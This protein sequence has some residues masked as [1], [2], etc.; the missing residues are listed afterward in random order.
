MKLKHI[1]R[2]IRYSNY[3]TFATIFAI[4]LLIGTFVLGAV[5]TTKIKNEAIKNC[6]QIEL[7]A[8]EFSNDK[9]QI[10][11]FQ[12]EAIA[13][14]ENFMR[15]YYE[16][17]S[18]WLNIWLAALALIMTILGIMIPICFIKFL[19]NKE[20]EMDRII[21]E[22]KKQ[23]DEMQ[24]KVDDVEKKY[25]EIL[26]KSLE[27]DYALKNAND[28]LR[29]IQE[30]V[31]EV[32]SI[33]KL[34][35][36]LS[37]IKENKEEEA[38]Q[39]FAE[40][41]ECN[42][43]NDVAL[44][45]LSNI[46]ADSGNFTEAIEL[47]KKAIKTK[48]KPEYYITYAKLLYDIRSIQEAIEMAKNA[49]SIAENNSSLSAFA[50]AISAMFYAEIKNETEAHKC[51]KKAFE[52]SKTPSVKRKCAL[53]YILLEYYDKGIELLKEVMKVRI[54]NPGDYYNLTEAYILNKQFNE[55]L[56]SLKRYV[57]LQDKKYCQGIFED[58]FEKWSKILD[59][60][61]QTQ[62]TKEIKELMD[63]LDKRKR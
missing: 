3:F 63:S 18:N 53:A 1:K 61:E 60:T 39:L 10:N 46:K 17:Q 30:N 22:T 28:K 34:N 42:P 43:Q 29:E 21:D 14:Q 36:A 37:R 41:L 31:I 32:K 25:K 35:E 13:S 55:A 40:S 45:Y 4:F 49:I 2:Y 11:T 59:E 51:I 7:I 57:L 19:E 26:E 58:D 23:K 33:T 50:Y 6:K 54:N 48:E 9:T 5:Y 62:T 20:K 24:P 56:N 8:K 47:I 16:I 44:Y 15:N 12:K 27:T 52:I 38:E